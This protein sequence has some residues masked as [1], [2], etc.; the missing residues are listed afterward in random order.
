MKCKTKL[1]TAL[2]EQFKIESKTHNT[3]IHDRSLSSLGTLS[4]FNTMWRAKLVL[5][6]PTSPR[7]EKMRS[8]MYFPHVFYMPTLK[9]NSRTALLYLQS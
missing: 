4:H 3:P 8:C 2:S 5:M 9:Y 1:S 7:C 6:F